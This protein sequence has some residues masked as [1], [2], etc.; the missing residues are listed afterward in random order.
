MENQEQASTEQQY[1]WAVGLDTEAFPSNA[2]IGDRYRVTSSQIV[3]DTD[4]FT[5][6]VTNL[7]DNGLGSLRQAILDANTNPGGD[8]IQFALGWTHIQWN[9]N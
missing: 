3:V 4:P 2:L 6:I 1:L 7:A 5:F 8:I 9:R